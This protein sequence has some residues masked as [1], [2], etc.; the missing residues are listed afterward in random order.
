MKI[1]IMQPTFIA[2]AS[3]FRLF[4]AS[5]MFVVL[6]SVQ[7]DRRWHT[8]RQKLTD[9]NGNKQWLTLPIK[10]TDR[11]R[12]MIKDLQWQEDAQEKW[13]EQIRKFSVF[14]FELPILSLR[15]CSQEICSYD[16]SVMDYLDMT[17]YSALREL[18]MQKNNTRGYNYKSSE[19]DIDL[20]LRGQERILAICQ[21]LGATEY[22]NS[23]GGRH[24][25]DEDKFS[26][27]NIKLTFLPE[28]K[29]S[30]DSILERLVHEKPEDIRKEIYDQI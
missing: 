25:Y 4:A 8:H 30:Y 19:L 7:F 23:P 27:E 3:Y 20:D 12:T 15:H 9:R 29:G 18:K 16:A 28:W 17:M 6:D 26:K 10:K 24:L 2:P 22:I 11:D 5:D 14:D 21:K 13:N 1:A